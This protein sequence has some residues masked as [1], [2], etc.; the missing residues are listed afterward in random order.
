MQ[1]LTP[2]YSCGL[3][4]RGPHFPFPEG[5]IPFVSAHST[6]LSAG[7]RQLLCWAKFDS[8]DTVTHWVTTAEIPCG[9]RANNRQSFL[10]PESSS[11]MRSASPIKVA[12][13]CNTV[14]VRKGLP[15]PMWILCGFLAPCLVRLQGFCACDTSWLGL[16]SLLIEFAG[17]LSSL[18]M[19]LR[20]PPLSPGFECLWG[21]G[22]GLVSLIYHHR[23]SCS[24]RSSFPFSALF[25]SSLLCVC[26]LCMGMSVQ[27]CAYRGQS[28]AWN[29]FLCCCPHWDSLLLKWELTI[30]SSWGS[31]GIYLSPLY[32]AKVTSIYTHA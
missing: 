20:R 10:T 22:A 9:L 1:S 2:G 28:K 15:F 25:I 31:F 21:A 18:L 26:M 13:G 4:T 3:E 29:A 19:K 6:L 14:F 12:L 27:A 24:S 16:L 30:L 11:H 7:F 17:I 23:S 5:G 32:D 8:W